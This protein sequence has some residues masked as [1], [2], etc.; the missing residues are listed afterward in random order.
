MRPF[1]ENY[2]RTSH[3]VE[4]PPVFIFNGLER[5]IGIPKAK[6]IVDDFEAVED[7]HKNFE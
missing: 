1:N 3:K 6:S 2:C 5:G 4:D 7:K